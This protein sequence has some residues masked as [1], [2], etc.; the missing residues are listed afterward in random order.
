MERWQLRQVQVGCQF[1]EKVAV[2]FEKTTCTRGGAIGDR[3]TEGG[4]LKGAG[5]ITV[6]VW[7]NVSRSSEMFHN[8]FIK[9][10]HV[11]FLM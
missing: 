11:E 3:P 9:S 5:S 7:R 1:P 6:M 4:A 8:H 10:L 2:G